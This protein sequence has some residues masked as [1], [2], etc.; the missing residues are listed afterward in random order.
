METGQDLERMLEEINGFLDDPPMRGSLEHR[1]FS[2]LAES[3]ERLRSEAAGGLFAEQ[4]RHLETRINAV[5]RRRYVERHAHD[6]SPGDRG[7][8]PMLGWDFRHD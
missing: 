4:L 5:V 3:I 2:D 7:T 6:L 1:R 8:T